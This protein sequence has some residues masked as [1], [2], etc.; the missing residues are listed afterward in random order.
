MAALDQ[1]PHE[2]GLDGRLGPL[3]A[4]GG[5]EPLHADGA[6]LCRR[7]G[8][9]SEGW[10][11]V[12]CPAPTQGPAPT[13]G[14]GGHP[15][16]A[17]HAAHSPSSGTGQSHAGR[18]QIPARGVA[19]A[20]SR[21]SQGKASPRAKPPGTPRRSHLIRRMPHLLQVF[22]QHLLRGFACGTARAKGWE[23]PAA[24]GSRGDGGTGEPGR[25]GGTISLTLLGLF[26]GGLAAGVGDAGDGLDLALA[27]GR[28][29]QHQLGGPGQA[30]GQPGRAHEDPRD[31][32]ARR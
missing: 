14:P 5:R 20:P 11:L 4:R 7:G 3:V 28:G 15:A 1:L 29:V 21:S 18:W 22:L 9:G 32:C 23:K 8:Q 26:L 17:A 6:V 19:R 30:H 16:G 10:V 27:D 13:P 24:R 12:G 2:V 31:P 25:A